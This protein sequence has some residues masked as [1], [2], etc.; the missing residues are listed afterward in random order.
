ML[1]LAAHAQMSRA[2]AVS[3]GIDVG[4]AIT[5]SA[6][7]ESATG[8]TFL[9]RAGYEFTTGL[10]PEL[11]V[12]YSHWTRSVLGSDA[13]ESE[14]SV[15]PGLRWSILGGAFR[16][17][18]SLHIGYG[19]LSLS[20]PGSD[21]SVNGIGVNTG[22]GLDWMFL[23]RMGVGVHLSWNKVITSTRAG[24]SMQEGEAWIDTGAGIA[25]LW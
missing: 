19:S 4:A 20:L 13:S 22:A 8:P 12:S 16:P 24:G 1:P 6:G 11:A 17:W 2:R 23:P 10:T 5:E 15:L 25:L 3:V 7:L 9:A 18:V 21:A 14:I